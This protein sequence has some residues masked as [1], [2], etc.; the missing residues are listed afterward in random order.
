M[1]PRDISPF[2]QALLAEVVQVHFLLGVLGGW[3]GADLGGTARQ[4]DNWCIVTG[5]KT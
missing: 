1:S 2:F 3:V 5:V 4:A